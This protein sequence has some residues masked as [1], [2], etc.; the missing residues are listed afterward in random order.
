MSIT[1]QLAATHLGKKSLGS[2]LYDKSLLVAVPRFENRQQYNIEENNLPFVGYDIWDAYEVSF[3]T[4]N[5][6]PCT[7]VLKIKYPANNP[8]IVESKSL[9]LY[10]NSFNMTPLKATINESKEF[11]IETVKR[12]LSDLLKT[13]VSLTLHDTFSASESK[14][15][16]GYKNVQDIV[17]L[18]TIVCTRFNEAPDELEFSSDNDGKDLKISFDAVRSNCKITHQPDFADIFIHIKSD[19]GIDISGLV[20]YI[21]SFRKENHFHEECVEMIYKRLFDKYTPDIIMVAA[22]YTRRGGIDICPIRA[23]NIKYLD[24]ELLDITKY[25]KR[26]IKQ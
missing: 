23:N 15:F 22:L 17:D 6:I 3:M 25:T 13:D 4:Q 18:D 21:V 16:Q 9:K 8:F 20:K 10:L 24:E 19:K 7:Y 5:N 14:M 12:D 1:E 11:F 2:E 26:T